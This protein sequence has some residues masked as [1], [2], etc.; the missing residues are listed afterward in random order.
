MVKSAFQAGWAGAIMKTTSVEEYPVHISYPIM[1]SMDYEGEEGA[2]PWGTST[3]SPSGTWMS[4][5]TQ[6][7]G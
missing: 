3:T 5:K 4:W 1:T 7:A 2:S 6:S